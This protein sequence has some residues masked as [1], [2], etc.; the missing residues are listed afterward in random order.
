MS[1]RSSTSLTFNSSHTSATPSRRSLRAASISRPARVTRRANRSG[2]IG[3]SACPFERLGRE[4]V[5]AS[6]AGRETVAAAS[7][8]PLWRSR[9]TSIRSAASSASSVG[10]STVAFCR[11]LSTQA[12]SW[13][14]DAYGV[15]KIIPRPGAPSDLRAGRSSPKRP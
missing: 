9:S 8:P 6:A 3:D 15:S 4:V 5:A 12:T 10:A 2:R 11:Q 7:N 13:R 14:L 1:S